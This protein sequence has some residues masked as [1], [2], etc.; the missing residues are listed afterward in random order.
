[1]QIQVLYKDLNVKSKLPLMLFSLM[2]S[3]AIVMGLRLTLV[4]SACSLLFWM[5]TLVVSI[6]WMTVD[7]TLPDK[8]LIRNGLPIFLKETIRGQL[9]NTFLFILIDC[10]KLDSTF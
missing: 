8:E 9:M 7:A 6:G 5:T 10:I 3:L 4:L 2:I 1:M